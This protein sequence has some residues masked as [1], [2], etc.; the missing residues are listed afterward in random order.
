MSHSLLERIR[1]AAD[2]TST[3]RATWRAED[4]ETAVVDH[5]ERLLST[6][7][8]GS[9]T[10]PDYGVPELSELSNNFVDAL[11][12]SQRA[13]KAC[14]TAYEPRVKNVQVRG[15]KF[16]LTDMQ[17]EFEVTGSIQHADGRKTA[18]RI[19][20]GIDPSAKLRIVR[21]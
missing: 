6:R 1:R 2:P 11:A 7:Q 9:L 3:E 13:L 10:A 17:F 21:E 4:L 15:T 8:G 20:L 5:L 16:D 12:I 19:T 18:L 14:L